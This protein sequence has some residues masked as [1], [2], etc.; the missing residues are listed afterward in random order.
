M[1]LSFSRYCYVLFVAENYFLIW[2][3]LC[4]QTTKG[5]FFDMLQC[6]CVELCLSSVY[7]QIIRIF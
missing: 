5:R 4:W 1:F 6:S 3:C 2:S 7:D